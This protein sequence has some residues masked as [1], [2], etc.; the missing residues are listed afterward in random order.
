MRRR[1]GGARRRRQLVVRRVVRPGGDRE[2]PAR[3]GLVLQLRDGEV[4]ERRDQHRARAQLEREPGAAGA[5]QLADAA[6][7]GGAGA[8]ARALGG[9]AAGRGPRARARPPRRRVAGRAAAAARGARRAARHARRAAAAR[10]AAAVQRPRAR[11]RRAAQAALAT[12]TARLLPKI[13]STISFASSTFYVIAAVNLYRW[14][15]TGG[16][17]KRS[18]LVSLGYN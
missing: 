10:A 12:H 2:A 3:Q 18:E 1:T 4:V 7:R 15:L 8:R 13:M 16:P 5:P 17:R 11:R 14:F 9:R 6:A